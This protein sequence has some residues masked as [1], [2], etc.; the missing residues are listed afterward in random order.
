MRA[1]TGR[2]PRVVHVI[3]N[4]D[5]GGAETCLIELCRGLGREHE[6]TVV[7]LLERGVLAEEAEAAGARVIALGWRRALPRPRDLLRL[8]ETIETC[9]PDILQGWMYQANLAVWAAARWLRSTAVLV[10]NLRQTPGHWESE[11]PLTTRLIQAGAPLADQPAA[12]IVNA[13]ANRDAHIALGYRPARWEW[14]PNGFDLA[15][16]RR[17]EVARARLRRELG[18]A[19]SERLVGLIARLHPV[20]GQRR[21]L[22]AAAMLGSARGDV[23]YLLAGRGVDASHP[24]IAGWIRELGLEGRVRCLGE[25]RDIPDLMNALDIVC[26]SSTSESFPNCV[27]EAMACG[28]PVVSTPVGD[29]RHL[30]GDAGVVVEDLSAKAL[31]RG[32]ERLLASSDEERSALGGRARARIETRFSHAAMVE[33]YRALYRQLAPARL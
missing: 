8:A 9:A 23:S 5:T 2:R 30:M 20:K 25:R 16:F 19:E 22:E 32:I 26:L 7:T 21:F 27:G 17:D 12:V 6:L 15:R 13:V 29:V 10:W 28:R 33:R 14:I 1:E 11:S 18:A 3:T 31:A 4:L 24:E